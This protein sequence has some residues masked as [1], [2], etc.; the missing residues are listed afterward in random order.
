MRTRTCTHTHRALHA[1]DPLVER[2]PRPLGM[3]FRA[4]GRNFSGRGTITQICV[5][6]PLHMCKDHSGQPIIIRVK[7]AKT[8]LVCIYLLSG[9]KIHLLYFSVKTFGFPFDWHNHTVISECCIT[10]VKNHFLST[11]SES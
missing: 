3:D 4:L 9:Y 5:L 2:I 8:H 10:T 1:A 11:V 7:T 6:S